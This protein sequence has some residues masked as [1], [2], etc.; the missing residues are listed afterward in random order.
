MFTGSSRSVQFVVCF[1][2]EEFLTNIWIFQLYQ[3]L[4]SFVSRNECV[5]TIIV[6]KIIIMIK[7]IIRVKRIINN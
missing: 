1:D 7:I 2:K 5:I 6:I 4:A 3:L